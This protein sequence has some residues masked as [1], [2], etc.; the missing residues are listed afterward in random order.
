MVKF[1]QGTQSQFKSLQ[2]KDVNALYFI[3][4]SQRIYKGD[5]PEPV[6]STSIKFVSELPA[7]ADA[8]SDILYVY[9]DPASGDLVFRHWN[10]TEYEPVGGGTI[11]SGVEEGSIVFS[12]FSSEI[13]SSE[14]GEEA[15]S[16]KLVTET[17]VVGYVDKVKET[18][19]KS[20]QDLSDEVDTHN[21]AFKAARVDAHETDSSKITL[22]FTDFNGAEHKVDLDKEKFLKN[23]SLS[24]DGKTLTLTMTD[25]SSVDI[26]LTEIVADASTV[27]TTEDIVVTTKVGELAANSTIPAGTSVQDLLVRILSQEKNPTKSNPS[28]ASFSVTNNGEGTEFEAGTE[29]TPKWNATFGAGSY[30]YKSTASKDPITPVSGTGVAVTKWEIFQGNTS[31]SLIGSEASGVGDAY[32]LGDSNVTYTARVTYGDG[33]FALTNLNKLPETDV[34]ITGSTAT[35][36]AT[37]STFRKMFAG[38]VSS[39]AEVN[40]ALIRGLSASEKAVKKVFEFN[41]KVGDTRLLLAIP[42][43]LTTADPTF[44]YFTMSWEGFSGFTKLSTVQVADARGESYGMVDYTVYSYA[45]AS[46]FEAET[47]FRATIN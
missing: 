1:L 38:G 44:E 42:A 11:A 18:I 40:S 4:D 25:D 35:K 13:I 41:A 30:T 15:S 12:S 36:T 9:P 22:V 8:L 28:V 37:I 17:A 24:E 46:A 7:S 20:I 45:P 29:I 43:S 26:D 16:S 23:A 19:T 47:Q 34:Q 39:A 33:N 5:N 10:G 2:T 21:E 3:T 6:V 32:T 27:K 14:I 31:G